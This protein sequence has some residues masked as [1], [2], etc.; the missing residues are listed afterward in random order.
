MGK[1]RTHGI[2]LR[3]AQPEPGRERSRKLDPLIHGDAAP[4]GSGLNLCCGRFCWEIL[5]R[6]QEDQVHNLKWLA[7]G[8]SGANLDSLLHAVQSIG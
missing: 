6:P 7:G 1:D 5:H 3:R 2:S 4:Y 8:L